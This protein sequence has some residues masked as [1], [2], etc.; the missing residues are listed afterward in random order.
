MKTTTIDLSILPEMWLNWETTKGRFYLDCKTGQKYTEKPEA[1]NK[2]RYRGNVRLINSGSQP[3]FAY[4]KY[5]ED[6]ERLELA[7]ITMETTRKEEAKQW[8]Y[9][10]NKYF[11]GKDKSVVDEN[12]NTVT[13]NFYLSRYHRSN[14]FKGF[15][16]MFYRIEIPSN[17]SEFKKFLG[18]DTYVVGSGRMVN[19]S[20]CWHI[21]EWYKTTQ[22]V[23]GKGKQQKLT[24]E[25]IEMGVEDVDDIILSRMKEDSF[26]DV[27]GGYYNPSALYYERLDDGWSV[28]RHF[29][30]FG[31]NQVKEVE[32]MYIHDD[33]GNRIVTPSKDGW[34]PAKQTQSYNSVKFINRYEAMN[35]C[36]RLKYIVPILCEE[37]D[38]SFR[39][40]L[41]SVLRFPALEQMISLGHKKM[42]VKIARSNTPKADLSA[43]FGGYYNEREKSIYKKAGMNRHQ[44]TT[45]M[46]QVE[47]D[48]VYYGRASAVLKEM[49]DVFG[50]GFVHLDNTTFDKYYY[51]FRGMMQGYRNAI[52]PQ[53]KQL[54][55]DREKFIRN[56]IRLGDK[57]R[58]VYNLLNDTLNQYMRLNTGTEPEINWFF[59]SYSDVVRAHNAIDELQR[60]QQEERR[61]M[62]DMAEAERRKKEEA[63]RIKL[64]EERKKWEYEDSDYIIRLPK[65]LSEIVS[66]GSK[67]RI[68]IGGYTTRHAMGDTNIFFLRRKKE[69]DAPFYAIEVNKYKEVVQIHGYCNM[70]LGNNPE[71]IPTVIRWLRKN[72]FKCKKEILTCTAKGYCSV[73]HYVPMPVVD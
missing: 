63:K 14:D 41:I 68:C 71:A 57:N 23:R 7:E 2:Y 72:G 13:S 20:Y 15:L 11:L 38:T 46:M 70:W 16:S 28:L 73:N 26:I 42:S 9:V 6:I 24:D 40:C 12:G 43:L 65:D 4:A 47:A 55:I 35:Q 10:G 69:L 56:A 18:S 30:L 45:H 61:A 36:D 29:K 5:H 44:F 50:N 62:W 48:G 34:V 32:R 52:Y 31:E 67:Q 1:L 37:S 51:A 3:R 33:G 58:N 39:N 22:K 27:Y 17:V 54:D 66:E 8:K 53:L 59:D 60:A 25:L 64:D 21:Q 19:V 49:R